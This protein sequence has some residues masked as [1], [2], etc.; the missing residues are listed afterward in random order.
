M[1]LYRYSFL[2]M[3]LGA[4]SNALTGIDASGAVDPLTCGK[5]CMSKGQYKRAAADLQVAVQK[6]PKSCEGHLL[7]GQV[8]CKLKENKQ[9]KEQFRL[10]IRVGH[11]STNAQKANVEMM[12]L[13]QE[14]LAPKTGPDTQKLVS[15]LNLPAAGDSPSKPTVIDFY[16]TW[17][18][19]CQQLHTTLE[20]AKTA[21][22]DK[23]NFVRV[24]VDDE[25]NQKLID[26]YEV[27]PIPTVV[28]LNTRG[29]VVTFS[30]GFSGETSINDEIKKILEPG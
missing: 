9:A 11:G 30:I 12:K 24:D 13:P 2:L 6:S 20:K 19:P 17:C 14:L 10:A 23:I 3:F 16:A 29:E 22:G 15:M 7:L 26:Q 25:K 8:Y 18:N 1:R 28:Y 27:S 4:F 5:A 21:Y